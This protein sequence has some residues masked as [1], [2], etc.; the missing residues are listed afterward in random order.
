M[1]K[2]MIA[3]RGITLNAK[4]NSSEALKDANKYRLGYIEFDV[5]VTDDDIAVLSHDS[6]IR[7]L[8]IDASTYKE[9]KK[10]DTH[11]LMLKD[12]YK[13]L[14]NHRAIIDLKAD[15]SYLYVSDYLMSHRKSYATSFILPE[16]LSLRICGVKQDQTFI[17]Q[18]THPFGLITKALKNRI[19][20]ISINKFYVNPWI[21]KQSQKYGLN[22]MIYT[23]NSHWLAKIYR[24][25]Y[26]NALICTDRPD[27][28][29][30]LD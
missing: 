5:R 14:K 18:H 29:Q 22:I 12:A 17:A 16:I 6:K 13:I 11:L 19:G 23:V 1:K 2:W 10:Q 15:C 4:E 20:G 30:Q 26:P 28:L 24:K 3:H 27:R 25:I 7:E 21:Y 9:L 8:T